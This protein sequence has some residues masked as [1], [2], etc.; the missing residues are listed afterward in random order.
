[1]H[2]QPPPTAAPRQAIMPDRSLTCSRW[3]ESGMPSQPVWFQ[4]LDEILALLRGLD[5]SHQ[6]LEAL[7]EDAGVSAQPVPATPEQ[8]RNPDWLPD[9]QFWV[10]A[11]ECGWTA[12]SDWVLGFKEITAP[13]NVRT[14]I[15]ALL[16]TVGF[17]NKVPILKPEATNRAEWLLAANLNAT[18]L[19]FVARQ[20][21]QGQ[22]LNLFIVEQLP[23]VPPRPLRGRPLRPQD[24]W[25]DCPRGRS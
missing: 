4:R 2:D 19:D 6:T 5:G 21:I 13:T 23:V 11:S 16:P 15:A 24:G 12:G 1:M 22:T 8:H 9:A 20:K 17:G 10:P 7:F 3:K 14:F 18:I 25:R